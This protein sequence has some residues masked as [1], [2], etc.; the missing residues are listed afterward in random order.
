MYNLDSDVFKLR[1][2]MSCH[3]SMKFTRQTFSPLSP[4][5]P[6]SW[7]PKCSTAI[8]KQ[9]EN[10]CARYCNSKENPPMWPIRNQFINIHSKYTLK[11]NSFQKGGRLLYS[12]QCQREKNCS[13][14]CEIFH[15]MTRS[16]SKLRFLNRHKTV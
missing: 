4:I 8:E 15:I 6:P 10:N 13:H 12:E 1:I 7:S 5:L 9:R 11:I 3:S 16:R 2:S 14:H